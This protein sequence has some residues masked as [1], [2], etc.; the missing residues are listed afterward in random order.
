[1]LQPFLLYIYNIRMQILTPIDKL[2]QRS[3]SQHLPHLSKATMLCCKTPV[4]IISIFNFIEFEHDAIYI[5]IDASFAD[6]KI[7]AFG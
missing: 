5:F 7:I 1:M 2:L 3:S 4:N 6:D